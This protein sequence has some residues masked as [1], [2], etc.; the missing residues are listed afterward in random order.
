[1]ALESGGSQDSGIGRQIAR[2]LAPARAALSRLLADMQRH[3]ATAN[4]ALEPF[5]TPV[6]KAI[7]R[8]WTA[9]GNTWLG[10][11][12]SS[13]LIRRIVISNILGLVILLLGVLYLSQF[14][15]W[16]ID[17]KR[18]SLQVRAQI[19]AGALAGEAA[20]VS[21]AGGAVEAPGAALEVNP[22]A[23]LEFSLGPVQVT[24]ALRR[25]LR[26]TTN[27]AR[28]YDLKGNLIHDSARNLPPG[29]VATVD[30]QGRIVH[31][32]RTKNF[33]TKL[34]QWMLS[35]DLRVY[36]ELG[37][38]NGQLYPEVR[39]ALQGKTEALMLLTSSGEQIVSIATPIKRAGAVQGVL[40]LST[41]PG[42]IDEAVGEQR[43]AIL[44]LALLALLAAMLA[45]WL[46]A[47]TV[48]GPMREL[49]EVAEDVTR[50]I[51]SAAQLPKF[52]D[53]E[54]EVG[55]LTRA[56]KTMTASLYR[57]IEASERF[58]ADVA[59]ELKNPLAAARSMAQ[60]L[61]YAKTDE[62]RRMVAEQ[63]QEELKRLN[64]LI[65]DVSSASRL[66]AEL[67][68]QQSEPVDL[69]EVAEGIVATF[70]DLTSETGK[71]VELSFDARARENG[72]FVVSGHG[73]R[74]GQV[75]T[76]LIDNALSFSPADGRVV[77][78]I[79]RDGADVVLTVDDQGPGIDTDQLEKIFKRFY[80]Y[81]PTA[82]SS[83]GNNSGLG[84]SIS[85]DIVL[86][87][88]GEIWA[89]N[90]P[91]A[92]DG[93]RTGARFT[94]RIPAADGVSRRTGRRRNR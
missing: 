34:T 36:K 73:G 28:V 55:Q 2:R 26:D 6:G 30:D 85:R 42:E 64:R 8:V 68:L 4:A 83:R 37:D 39:V 17:S 38:A 90:R 49:S 32:P 3:V 31:R 93:S 45:S 52:D 63:I 13:S 82:E 16:L 29:G 27:R 20:R 66:E 44:W 79:T 47:R 23:E 87:H 80:T 12:V 74:L 62:Q 10:R 48:A 25:L 67:A 60:A 77:A 53:R 22:F 19:I 11:R 18:E 88:G 43:L 5:T 58:A 33:W 84:L 57:R 35:S 78:Q 7:E 61:E 91:A 89:E 92:K 24:Q 46:L 59:H 1:M 71:T 70:R 69:A 14:N 65:T 81:R 72:V 54:D 76:N 21:G 41:R 51:H 75:M 86:R 94:V 15:V 9:A 56:F 40:L 50:N